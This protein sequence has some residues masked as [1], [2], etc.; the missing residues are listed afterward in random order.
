MSAIEKMV[1]KHHQERGMIC[2]NEDCWCWDY[3][4]LVAD[5]QSLRDE[6]ARLKAEREWQPIES[7]PRKRLY[8]IL[9]RDSATQMFASVYWYNKENVWVD[10]EGEYYMENYF[11]HWMPLPEPPEGEK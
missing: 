1:D 11:T 4:A 7:A 8:F 6:I 2:C 3:D 9:A 10:Y 5:N